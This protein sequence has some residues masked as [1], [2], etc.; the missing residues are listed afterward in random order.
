[1][2][3]L[4]ATRAAIRAGYSKKTAYS[5]GQENL[6]KPEI[7]AYWQERIKDQEERTEITQDDVIKGLHKEATFDGEGSTHSARVAAWAHLGMFTD[8]VKIDANTTIT[9]K[10]LEDF[11]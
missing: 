11:F 8:K 5:I 6:T 4:N 7:Q 2:N 9:D 1:M 3:D 10:K